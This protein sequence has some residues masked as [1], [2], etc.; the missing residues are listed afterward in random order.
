[1]TQKINFSIKLSKERE[2]ERERKNERE[3]E[4]VPCNLWKSFLLKDSTENS[5]L[6]S[7]NKVSRKII[8]VNYI[9]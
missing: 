1:L 2:R 5:K 6:T 9:K 7:K 3:R 8:R 4:R